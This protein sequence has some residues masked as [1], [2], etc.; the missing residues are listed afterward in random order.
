MGGLGRRVLEGG[1]GVAGRIGGLC[2]LLFCA[3]VA[4][5]DSGCWSRAS[6]RHMYELSQ[7]S[8]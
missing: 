1:A 7:P 4:A 2:L 5:T 3:V 8:Q 6:S